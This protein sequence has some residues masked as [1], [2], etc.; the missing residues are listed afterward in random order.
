LARWSSRGRRRSG[1]AHRRWWPSDGKTSRGSHDRT[2][3]RAALHLITAF[4]SREK[5]VLAQEA[6]AA[7]GY[8]QT[9]IQLLLERLARFFLDP[10]TIVVASATT[11]DKGQGRTEERTAS[12]STSIVWRDGGQLFPKLAQ[13]ASTTWGKGKQTNS[14]RYYA[15]SCPISPEALA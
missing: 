14:M 11:L 15:S 10:E 6:I 8:E 2:N 12:V 1:L 5:L 3:G 4:A 13:I 7:G 9:S